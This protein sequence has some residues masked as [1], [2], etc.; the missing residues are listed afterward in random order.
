M[1]AIVPEAT[2]SLIANELGA[3]TSPPTPGGRAGMNCLR[4]DCHRESSDLVMAKTIGGCRT[5]HGM[6][7]GSVT[8]RAR[9]V[10]E[11]QDCATSSGPPWFLFWPPSRGRIELQFGPMLHA[12]L[13]GISISHTGTASLAFSGSNEPTLYLDHVVETAEAGNCHM[14][15]T[16]ALRVRMTSALDSSPRVF[17]G[18]LML[19]GG[20]A[21]ARPRAVVFTEVL[22]VKT[23]CCHPLSGTMTIAPSADDAKSV[24]DVR[25]GSRVCGQAFVTDGLG[26]TTEIK[27]P[28]C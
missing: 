22:Y 8:L 15:S 13:G 14:T 16:G 20:Y 2:T 28:E 27:L 21:G 3:L 11:A 12:E 19:T 9:G 10:P 1:M 6:L 18:E 17:N 24:F 4:T 25:F 23:Q 5:D 26:R 7:T